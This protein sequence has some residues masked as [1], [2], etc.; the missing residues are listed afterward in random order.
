MTTQAG[1]GVKV[2]GVRWDGERAGYYV[3]VPN[4]EGGDVV[5]VADYAALQS[6]RDALSARA[7]QLV[8]ALQVAE[9]SLSKLLPHAPECYTEMATRDLAT[10][11]AA[12]RGG[13]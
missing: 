1:G 7:A 12:L 13:E 4:W 2:I 10:I 3:D 11:R 5:A 9:F 8:Q 6:E